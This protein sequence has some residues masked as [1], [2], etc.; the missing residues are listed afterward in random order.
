MHEV[1]VY[2]EAGKLKKIISSKTL[3]KR[4]EM[5][6]QSPSIFRKNQRN[7]KPIAKGPEVSK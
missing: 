6:I 3:E 7:A 4:A 5:Q 2:D 1:R